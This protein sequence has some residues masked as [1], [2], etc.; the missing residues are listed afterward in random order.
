MVHLKGMTKLGTLKLSGTKIS[1]AG[2]R[3]LKGLTSLKYLDLK[4]TSVTDEG[5]NDL[6]QALSKCTIVFP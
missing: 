5:V 3:H 1:N 2:L 4:G 6:K